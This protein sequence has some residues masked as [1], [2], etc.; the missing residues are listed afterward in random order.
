MSAPSK[1]AMIKAAKLRANITSFLSKHPDTQYTV[2]EIADGIKANL[3]AVGRAAKKM[4]ADELIVDAGKVQGKRLYMS[5]KAL[6]AQDEFGPPVKRAP[7][8]AKEV[9]LVVNG[10]LVVVGRNEKTG[11]IRIVLEDIS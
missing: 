7:R 2:S 8:S 3:N 6:P 11:R 1:K 4:A 9:E 10:T 5:T